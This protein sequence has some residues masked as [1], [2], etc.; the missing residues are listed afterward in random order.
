[1]NP[2]M[3]IE[4]GKGLCYLY[5]RYKGKLCRE[6][7]VFVPY[8]LKLTNEQKKEVENLLDDFRGTTKAKKQ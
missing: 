8:G 6:V 7:T 1:M 5:C 4:N 3:I 2:T